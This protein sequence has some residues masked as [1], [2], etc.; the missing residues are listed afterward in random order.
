MS[1]S[2][3]VFLTAGSWTCGAGAGASSGSVTTQLEFLQGTAAGCGQEQDPII[4]I[5]TE[6]LPLS[7]GTAAGSCPN[8]E[9]RLPQPPFLIRMFN[10]PKDREA[11][12]FTDWGERW[13][14]NLSTTYW[15]AE[16]VVEQAEEGLRADL[17]RAKFAD[18]DRTAGVG[19]ILWDSDVVDSSR[20]DSD[21]RRPA[22]DFI[23]EAKSTNYGSPTLYDDRER[24]QLAWADL[25]TLWQGT[26]VRNDCFLSFVLS[27]YPENVSLHLALSVLGKCS[28]RSCCY[29]TRICP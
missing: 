26:E 8:Q 10:A 13:E 7:S 23:R 29:C 18:S 20:R 16:D 25:D 9:L 3:L 4:A 15:P 5:G 11:T 1:L 21:A 2:R 28:C 6:P 24:A 14:V 27:W 17:K 12:E 22:G 19:M